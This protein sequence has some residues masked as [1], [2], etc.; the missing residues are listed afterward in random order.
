M[1]YMN[2]SGLFI[3][4]QGFLDYLSDILFTFLTTLVLITKLKSIS[5]FLS[6]SLLAYLSDILLTF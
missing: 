5:V 6:V 1:T 4:P 2:K 3:C